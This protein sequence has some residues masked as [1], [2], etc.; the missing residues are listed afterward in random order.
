MNFWKEESDRWRSECEVLRLKPQSNDQLTN[1]YE[2]HIR[3]LLELKQIAHSEA[4]SLW[5]ENMALYS[6][7]E[8]LIWLNKD[9]EILLEKKNEEL[10]TTIENYKSQ[11][12]AMTEH[13]AAQNDKITKQCD[14]IQALKHR[15][16]SKK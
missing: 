9:L 12:D 6:R 15:I 4:K 13:L 7:L 14:E 5:S 16:A 3:E 1:F 11:L 8:N 10:L 2:S